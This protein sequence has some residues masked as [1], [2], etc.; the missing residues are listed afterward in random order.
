MFWNEEQYS[1]QRVIGKEMIADYKHEL[2]KWAV[3]EFGGR[4]RAVEHFNEMK[5]SVSEKTFDN[6]KNRK[7]T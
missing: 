6:W 3:A 4:K 7:L 5:D 1:T 2:G